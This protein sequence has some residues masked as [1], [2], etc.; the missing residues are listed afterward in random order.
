MRRRWAFAVPLL[1]SILLTGCPFDSKTPIGDPVAGSFDPRLLGTWFWTDAGSG[2]ITE[3]RVFR[4]NSSE[5]YLE[6]QDEGKE[7]ERDRMYIVTVG[8]QQFLHVN[9]L[10]NDDAETSYIFARYSISETGVLLVRFVGDKAVPESLESDRKGLIDFLASHLE[11]TEL[12]DPD[13]PWLLT[14]S[15]PEVKPREGGTK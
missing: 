9:N 13:G 3:F 8:G 11:D 10:T 2:Q 6:T 14:R 4:F 15:K 1:L 12:D 5:Y 7:A